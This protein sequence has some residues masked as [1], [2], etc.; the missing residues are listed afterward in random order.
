MD[1]S[2]QIYSVTTLLG[3]DDVSIMK[4]LTTSPVAIYMYIV[5]MVH[6]VKGRQYSAYT[7]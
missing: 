2:E 6:M 5:L 7:V 4:N 3:K 1:P